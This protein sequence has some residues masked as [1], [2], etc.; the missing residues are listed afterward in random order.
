MTRT[1]RQHAI[2][3]HTRTKKYP[4]AN[5]SIQN[6]SFLSRSIIIAKIWK[7]TFRP[8]LDAQDTTIYE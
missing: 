1:H 5:L 6:K 4:T 8:H 7:D 3:M 2:L